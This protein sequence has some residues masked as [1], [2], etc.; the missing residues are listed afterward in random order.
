MSA[1]SMF[2]E[3]IKNLQEK[4]P[5][6]METLIS[7]TGVRYGNASRDAAIDWYRERSTQYAIGKA[8]EYLA[9]A[10]EYLGKGRPDLAAPII[11]DAKT[12]Y[13][14]PT[15]I[16]VELEYF[17]QNDIS[18]L[19][20]RVSHTSRMLRMV[21]VADSLDMALQYYSDALDPNR[22]WPEVRN[23]QNVNESG[24]MI[25]EAQN[26]IY[27]MIRR[28]F[29]SKLQV[30][31]NPDEIPYA[32]S[33]EVLLKLEKYI[34][35][36]DGRLQDEYGDKYRQLRILFYK[37]KEVSN[38][39]ISTSPIKTSH[40]FVSYSRDDAD[41]M[42]RL[43]KALIEANLQVW[44]DDTKIQ[45]GS[46]SWRKLIQDAIEESLC[47]VVILTPTSRESR[48]VN[49]ELDYAEAHQKTIYPVLGKGDMRTS[50]PFGFTSAQWIDIR[51][52]ERFATE[53]LK[54]IRTI[55]RSFSG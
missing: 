41:T 28:E 24:S 42:E 31:E 53:L 13:L 18:P 2:A 34:I 51:E 46:R 33:E 10:R 21:F 48:W 25:S 30:L 1:Q 17:E 35:W 16:R 39:S 43:T 49:A 37:K 20:Q 55:R 23:E 11:S 47:L 3:I 38:N 6:Y 9:A 5:D 50:V 52:D 8:Q 26:H 19:V 7:E 27:D 4:S 15:D 45:P 36:G 54:L 14:L 44:V 32:I 29:S 12:L 22:G 40:I